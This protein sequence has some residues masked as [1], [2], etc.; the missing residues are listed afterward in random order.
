M[1]TEAPA[2]LVGAKW[3]NRGLFPSAPE[4]RHF[5][6]R[7][8]FQS[9]QFLSFPASRVLSSHPHAQIFDPRQIPLDFAP[10]VPQ[11][12]IRVHVKRTLE[13]PH[14]VFQEHHEQF[15]FHQRRRV[16]K[17]QQIRERIGVVCRLG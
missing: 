3:R 12:I 14:A 6:T 5:A 17:R 2:Q 8:N 7:C 13:C 15:L 11:R 9:L 16:M 10:S 4:A 1:R